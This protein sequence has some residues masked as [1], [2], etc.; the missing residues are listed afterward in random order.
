VVLTKTALTMILMEY[1][2]A[3]QKRQEETQSLKNQYKDYFGSLQNNNQSVEIF[4]DVD[5]YGT[6]SKT[7]LYKQQ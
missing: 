2:V 3:S 4:T 1:M 7:T 6:T 5:N